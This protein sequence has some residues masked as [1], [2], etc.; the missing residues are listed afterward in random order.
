M[1]N[2]TRIFASGLAA[3]FALIFPAAGNA[4][5]GIPQDS[6]SGISLQAVVSEGLDGP[7]FVA[8]ARDGSNRLFIVERPG[9]VKVLQ[10]SS[11][12]PSSFLDIRARVL[13]TGDEQGLLGLAFHPQFASNGRFFVDYTR[14]PDGA[15]VVAEYHASGNDPNS[16]D[17]TEDVLLT[18]DQ[19]TPSHNGGMLAFGPD[20]YLYI[21]VGDGGGANDPD[22]RAQNMQDLHG[23]VL[24][25]DVDQ[26]DPGKAY[27]SPPDNPFAGSGAGRDEIYALGFRNPWR[28]SFDR[29]SGRL[30]LGDV[31]EEEVEEV[32]TVK[33]GGNYGWRVLEGNRCTGL[34]PAPCSEPGFIPPI[35]EY[36]HDGSRCAV[37]GGYVYRGTAATLPYGAYVFGDLCT[38]EIFLLNGGVQSVIAQGPGALSSFGEDESG[39]IYVVGIEGTIQRIVNTDA[40]A[41]PTLYIPAAAATSL[42]RAEP[43]EYTGMAVTNMGSD[44][45]DLTLTAFD[46][47]GSI[48]TGEGIDNPRHLPLGAG[49]QVAMIDSEV[50]GPRLLDENRL[51]WIK[52]E[53]S[54]PEIHAFFLDFNTGLTILEGA[55]AASTAPGFAVLPEIEVEGD[56]Q[57]RLTNP[58][59]TPA[60]ATIRLTG[61]DGTVRATAERSV[62]PSGTLLES[63]AELFPGAALDPQEYFQVLSAQ[64]L[65]SFEFLS[66]AGFDPWDVSGQDASAGSSELFSPQYV[67]GG[68]YL[69]RFSVVNLDSGPGNLTMQLFADDGTPLGQSRTVPIAANGKVRVDDPG[70]FFN[71][72]PI[73]A[74]GYLQIS[75]GSLRLAGSIVFSDP[76]RKSFSA[77]LPFVSSVQKDIIFSQ[78]ASNSDYFT[79]IAMLNP[80]A[81]TAT[82]RMDVCDSGGRVIASSRIIVLAHSRVSGLLTEYFPDLAGQ[83]L[84]SGYIRV[85][86]DTGLVTLALFGTNSLSAL[87]AIPPSGN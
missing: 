4:L 81:T 80:A 3:A 5:P 15:I 2:H 36:T 67:V 59:S 51:G 21:S 53:S 9:T 56:T 82:T 11:N 18:I 6:A 45:A 33:A 31:G 1:G 65:V 8:N 52:L 50:F 39:E 75:G 29:V 76:A 17:P 79:G 27:A 58:Y 47:S 37:I 85:T 46:S 43:D 41:M 20:G 87:S 70:F 40:P 86:S 73:L 71:S 22:N 69:T 84:H 30:Y 57:I 78:V 16:A 24:R 83:D 38:G 66:R 63:A 49:S 28:F 72:A 42:S 48:I 34:G 54:S 61:E 12:Q 7:L 14:S 26:Q 68:S 60:A 32:D 35:T 55:D 23:K 64:G 62:D 10:P 77:A 13:E 74:Q 19:P 44:V 25:I